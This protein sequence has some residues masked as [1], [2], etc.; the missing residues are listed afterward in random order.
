MRTTGYLLHKLIYMQPQPP[1]PEHKRMKREKKT[2]GYM[3]RNL[4]Q[5]PSR[6]S[7][8][9][10]PRVHRIPE[11]AFLRLDK[12]PF[13]DKKSTCGKCVIH[14]YK[15]DMKEKANPSCVTLDHACLFI[16]QPWRSTTLGMLDENHQC[17]QRKQIRDKL[18]QASISFSIG[19]LHDWRR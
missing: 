7:R 17:F 14:C 16:T 10:M 8:R 5:R 15:P 19:A 13:Q 6:H 4:L 11:Y 2:I 3:V 12:C 1:N 18:F 9:N